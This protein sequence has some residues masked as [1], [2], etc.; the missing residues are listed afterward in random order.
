MVMGQDFLR[1]K[2]GAGV[3]IPESTKLLDMQRL[4]LKLVFV[5]PSLVLQDTYTQPLPARVGTGIFVLHSKMT[6][7]SFQLLFMNTLSLI[8]K[9]VDIHDVSSN[10]T[11]VQ[12]QYQ[13]F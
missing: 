8:C 4:C 2:M 5:M 11:V 6:L 9:N 13:I 7:G 12:N 1:G 10:N 3:K